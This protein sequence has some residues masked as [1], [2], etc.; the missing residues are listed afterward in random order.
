GAATLFVSV[1]PAASVE[2]GS[3]NTDPNAN[4]GVDTDGDGIIDGSGDTD[5]DG[6]IDGPGVP[7]GSAT[8]GGGGGT[9][10]YTG[11]L[12][13]EYGDNHHLVILRE[14]P[15]VKY[16]VVQG[17]VNWVIGLDSVRPFRVDRAENP[18]RI[19]I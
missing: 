11:N 7:V 9:P 12:S 3:E 5:G 15:D 19:M 2:G 13:L 8:G 18:P 14:L 10:T 4:A 16:F 6:I 17:P 1:A